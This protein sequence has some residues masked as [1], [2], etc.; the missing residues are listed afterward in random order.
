[1]RRSAPRALLVAL[2]LALV[3]C[4]PGPPARGSRGAAT[5]AGEAAHKAVAA[6]A[7]F[8]LDPAV[9]DRR[10]ARYREWVSAVTSS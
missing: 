3:S 10:F 2:C 8:G 7:D 1:M 9:V 6:L 4:A 5:A